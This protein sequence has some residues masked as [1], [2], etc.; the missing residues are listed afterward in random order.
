MPLTAARPW[1]YVPVSATA[2]RPCRLPPTSRRQPAGIRHEASVTEPVGAGNVA[3]E[4]ED[5]AKVTALLLE[6]VIHGF[7]TLRIEVANG[8][9]VSGGLEK[10]FKN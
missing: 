2:T 3:I 8:K 10:K 7:A 9:I 1:V 4:M 6:G 5:V